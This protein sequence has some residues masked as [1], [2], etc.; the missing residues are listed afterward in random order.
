M[1]RQRIRLLTVIAAMA[2][3]SCSN[4]AVASGDRNSAE[5]RAAVEGRRPEF[6]NADGPIGR[7][8]WD[9]ER[10]FYE[11]NGYRLE[12]SDGRRSTRD[13]D[14]L[15]RTLSAAG[16]EG[17]EPSTYRVAELDA[18]RNSGTELD[19][20]ATYA[21]L[22]YARDVEARGND[23]VDALQTALADHEIE[24]SLGRLAPGAMPY[25]GLKQQLALARERGDQGAA[26]TI[27]RNMA[28]WRSLPADLGRRY[29]TVN[30]PAFRLDVIEDGTRVL[31]MK[32][33]TGK[34]SS[35]TPQ[36]ADEMT[37]IVFSPS[38]H[39]PQD[40]VEKEILPKL[41]RD[42]GYLDRHNIE[43][44]EASGRYRQRPGKGNSLGGVKFVFPNHFNVYLHDT[45]LQKLFE[46]V[47]RDF[48]HGC[49]RLDEPEALAAYVLRDKP[50]WTAERIRSAMTSGVEQ[51]VKLTAPL[52]IYLVYFTAWE[53]QGALKTVPDVYGLD[54]KPDGKAVKK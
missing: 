33:V 38:W 47:E 17:L 20:R 25:R 53:E 12:W 5:V 31:G 9:D 24:R 8:V 41:E 42:P 39:I 15:V 11:E 10:R 40:I 27:A 6:V 29:V 4:G 32:V 50:E 28:R 45:P 43:A 1:R 19:L 36:L 3:A 16:A 35:P 18:L 51:S 22:R 7:K 34:R 23:P 46:R 2:A 54:R 14:R 49:V 13:L 30:I 37:S 52:A 21:Y 44:D 26:Q 48:S